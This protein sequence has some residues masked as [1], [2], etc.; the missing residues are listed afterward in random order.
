MDTELTIQQ[1]ALRTGLSVHTLRYYE[2]IGLLDPVGR[3]DSGHRRYTEADMEWITLILHMR[4][5]DM[6]IADMQRFTALVRQGAHTIPQRVAILEAHRQALHRQIDIIQHTLGLLDAKLAHYRAW[7]ERLQAA[8]EE[9]G[10]NYEEDRTGY[11][12]GGG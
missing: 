7:G 4:E 5:S 11:D 3:A 6:P 8:G 2:R 1:V 10:H 9:Q 12:G